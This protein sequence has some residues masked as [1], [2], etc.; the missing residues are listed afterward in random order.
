MGELVLGWLRDLES[1]KLRD[2]EG[3][4]ECL[5]EPAE[6]SLLKDVSCLAVT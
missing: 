4:F 3:L 2:C 6:V 1:E 5:L